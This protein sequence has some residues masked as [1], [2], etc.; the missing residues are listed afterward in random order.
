MDNVVDQNDTHARTMELV[1]QHERD[2]LANE[3][4]VAQLREE[5]DRLEEVAKQKRKEAK[6]QCSFAESLTKP[7]SKRAAKEREEQQEEANERERAALA[8]DP[9]SAPIPSASAKKDGK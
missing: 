1:E 5:A 6:E 3:T 8:D 4:R 7:Q 2:A 9:R